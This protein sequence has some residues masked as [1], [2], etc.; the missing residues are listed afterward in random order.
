MNHFNIK[1]RF[2]FINRTRFPV[3]ISALMTEIRSF[4]VSFRCNGGLP[5]PVSTPRGFK[6]Y[7]L[8]NRSCW[9]T[10][11]RMDF[12][13]WFGLCL[14]AILI[15]SNYT[16]STKLFAVLRCPYEIPN[17]RVNDECTPYENQTCGFVCTTQ[18]YSKK[19]SNGDI[20]LFAM[21]NNNFSE[22]LMKAI[23]NTQIILFQI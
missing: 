22:I 20:I 2:I 11:C 21:I 17:G 16:F 19:N 12:M 4:L 3:I 10:I 15:K 9:S 1:H 6:R 23:S 7:R 5:T 18:G 14:E 13:Y 8:L